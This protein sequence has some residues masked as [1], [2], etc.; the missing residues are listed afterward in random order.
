M[1][2]P[3]QQLYVL[4]RVMIGMAIALCAGFAIRETVIAARG[5]GAIPAVLAVV[6]G[7]GTVVLAAYFR[8]WLRSKAPLNVPVNAGSMAARGKSPHPS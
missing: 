5:G 7:A 3:G 2:R 6:A 4:H 1:S 8:W